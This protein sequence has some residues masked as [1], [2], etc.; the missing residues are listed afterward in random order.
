MSYNPRDF[1]PNEHGESFT[2]AH[3]VFG[4]AFKDLDSVERLVL[5]LDVDAVLMEIWTERPDE[6]GDFVDPM[7]AAVILRQRIGGIDNLRSYVDCLM[8]GVER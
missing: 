7:E 6:Y 8:V 3:R 2:A 1:D 5:A 4:Q